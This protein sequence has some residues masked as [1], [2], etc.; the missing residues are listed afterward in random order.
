MTSDEATR[1]AKVTGEAQPKQAGDIRD[2]WWWVEPTVWTERMLTRLE[3]SEPTTVWFGLWDK[4]VS[5]RTLE[6]SLLGGLAQRRG[7]PESMAKPV[8]QFDTHL[9][10]ELARLRA[11][12]RHRRYRPTTG[13]PSLDRQTRFDG[14]ASAG[15]TSGARPD[16]G[17]GPEES[18]RTDI[19]ARLRRA[20]L[21]VSARTRMSRS[22][23][24]GRGT[25]EGRP[26]LVRGT[27]FSRAT[28]TRF[29]RSDCSGWSGSEWWTEAS[30]RCWSKA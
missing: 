30:W 28:L 29:R 7:L 6:G 1:T 12:L 4:V 10:V 14:E 22:G 8:K 16:G 24:A 23:Q 27:G 21:R 15:D 17:S 20:Q 2:R 13:A 26:R 11:E 18:A 19:R 9:P 25:P 3:N 5:E